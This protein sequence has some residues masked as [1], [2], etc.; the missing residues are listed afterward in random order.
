MLR[1][2]RS[3]WRVGARRCLSGREDTFFT[4]ASCAKELVG[5]QKL[6][7]AYK[8]G[9]SRTCD[10][11]EFESASRAEVTPAW[12]KS[13]MMAARNKASSCSVE[14]RST[15]SNFATNRCVLSNTSAA[16]TEQWN[17]S[18][19]QAASTRSRKLRRAFSSILHDSTSP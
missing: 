13:R 1:I 10:C 5:F 17:P 15:N 3:R 2:S 12:L 6:G 19:P 11:S 14:R 4:R 7:H 16:C 18:E 9:E 8:K